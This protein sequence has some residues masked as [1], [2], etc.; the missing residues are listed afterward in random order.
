MRILAVIPAC[1]GSESLPN[2]NMRLINGKPMIFHVIQNA[3]KSGYITDVLVT[4][5]S[6]EILTIARCMGVMGRQRDQSLCNKEVSLDAVVYDAVMSVEYRAYDYVVT[7]QSIS[8]T[9]KVETLDKAIEKCIGENL[10]TLISVVN[11]PSFS[12]KLIDDHVEPMQDKRMN[13][14]CLPPLY[15]ETGAFLI[16]KTQFVSENTRIGKNV[17]IYE[18]SGDEALDVYTYGDL[19]QADSILKK[20]QTAF[21]VNGNNEMGL[22]HI[23]RVLQL[24]DDFLSR[25]DI[26]YDMNQ[27]DPSVFGS[28]KY[29][30]YPVDGQKGLIEELKH[31]SYDRFINDNLSTTKEYMNE[32]KRAMPK[33]QIINFEDEG[34]GAEYADVVFNAL[35]DDSFLPNVYSGEKYYIASKLFLLYEPIFIKKKV[36]RVFV[37]F[38]GADPQNY[39][40][41]ILSMI[42]DN[43]EYENIQFCVV[44]GNAK[45][46]VDI[47]MQYNKWTNI[48]VY[49]NVSNIA[50]L[51]SQCDIAITSRGRTA[52]ELML[53]GIPTIAIAQNERESKH[54][55]LGNDNGVRYLGQN[56]DN[57]SILKAVDEYISLVQSERKRIQSKMLVNDLRNGRKNIMDVIENL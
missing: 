34:D 43:K 36:K 14:H 46:N 42:T 37:S 26:Y 15:I 5:N 25:P 22:G 20:K 38:G 39:S 40:D 9:L 7:M 19:K 30:I 44:I 41:R 32:L 27:T 56:P 35:Y 21:Y 29:P 1:E 55:F 51:M 13:R 54:S 12:W 18:L 48:E 33:A 23:Y 28:T 11:R 57:N 24:A 49:H 53:L 52:Y 3:K 8:P 2:K 6:D 10:D 17:D 4:T 50:E 16:T 45:Q 47:I 31:K